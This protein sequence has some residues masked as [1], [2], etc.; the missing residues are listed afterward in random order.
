LGNRGRVLIRASGTEPVLRV[1][2]EGL[3]I[4]EVAEGAK[5]I[6]AAFRRHQV[7][8]PPEFDDADLVPYPV[9]SSD[10]MMGR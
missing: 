9:A 8:V 1:L 5:R 4:V 10:E 2:V 7:W 3:D 6:G